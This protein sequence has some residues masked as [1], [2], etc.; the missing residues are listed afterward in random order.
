MVDAGVG[1]TTIAAG[2]S[3]QPPQG[4]TTAIVPDGGGDVTGK[5]AAGGT[6]GGLDGR[7][8]GGTGGRTDGGTGSPSCPNSGGP[9]MVSLPAGFCIDSTE[10]T[11]SQYE[12]WLRSN[13]P[14][15]GQMADCSS[16]TTFAPD[17]KCMGSA[18]APNY[19]CLEDCGNHPQVCIDWCD[20]YAYCKAVG[21]RL[22]GK[23]GG[24]AS[25]PDDIT[26]PNLSQWNCAC[27]SQGASAYP[28][29][30]TYNTKACNGIDLWPSGPP[31][32]QYETVPVGS[33]AT[34]QSSVAGYAGVF[35]LSGSVEEFEDSCSTEG[36]PSARRCNIRGGSFAAS[37]S[38]LRCASNVTVPRYSFANDIGFRCCSAP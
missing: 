6:G 27:T 38:H 21:K 2:G 24:G 23:I 22:C 1:G 5:D 17:A 29:G 8:D 33:M 30:A 15:T 13:P 31:P 9:S 25:S 20:A 12:A 35:D 7:T 4:G 36:E 11:R 18:T 32:Y 16:N 28:Y 19:V 14:T 3:A 34:C 26:N 37:V 10:V